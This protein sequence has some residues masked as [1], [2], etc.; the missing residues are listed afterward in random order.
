M[1]TRDGKLMLG[2]DHKRIQWTDEIQKFGVNWREKAKKLGKV[3]SF[4]S[5]L[6]MKKM[7]VRQTDYFIIRM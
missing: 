1:E 5:G 2:D 4:N 6:I 7:I 3:F